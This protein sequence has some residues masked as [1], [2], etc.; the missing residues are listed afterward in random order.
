MRAF[1]QDYGIGGVDVRLNMFNRYIP[2]LEVGLG[3]ARHTADEYGYTYRS[4]LA[5][6]AKVGIDYNFFSI[7]TRPTSFTAACATASRPSNMKS[8]A[9]PTP[10]HIGA[11]RQ[12]STSPRKAPRPDGWKLCWVCVCAYGAISAPAGR[13]ATTPSC[14]KATLSAATRGIFPGTAQPHRL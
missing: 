3:Q 9:P 7:P 2:T 8:P 6:Y 14:T 4:P 5:P 12:P 10:A 1:G 11:T 13:C